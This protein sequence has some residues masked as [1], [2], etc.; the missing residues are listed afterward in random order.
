MGYVTTS[1]ITDLIDLNKVKAHC[2]IHGT[3]ED[4]LLQMYIAAACMRFTAETGFVIG[5]SDIEYRADMFQNI[6]RL[7][8]S[9]IS[10]ITS[11]S[12]HDTEGVEQTI[13]ATE[14]LLDNSTH[15]ARIARKGEKFPETDRTPGNVIIKFKAGHDTLAELPDMVEWAI[16]STVA[17]M[18]E[19]REEVSDVR[20]YAVPSSARMV[21]DMYN[22]KEV[23]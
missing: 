18:Y 5:M 11:V 6:I 8:R 12:Y 3:E 23:L 17:H 4:D 1:Q 10:E 7:Y 22:V 16:L 21:M 9:P 20:S 19:N 14:I 13:P 15:P 2:Y